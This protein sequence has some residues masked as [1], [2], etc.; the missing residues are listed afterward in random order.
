MN[1]F[2][3]VSIGLLKNFTF[4]YED[5][6]PLNI[7]SVSGNGLGAKTH[8]ASIQIRKRTVSTKKLQA[9]MK[10]NLRVTGLSIIFIMQQ[11]CAVLSGKC[12]WL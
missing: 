11:R 2:K 3:N 12:R 8:S 7:L 1:A 6:S 10:F 9:H 5:E 4:T